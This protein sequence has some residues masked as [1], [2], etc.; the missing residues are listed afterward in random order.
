[1]E[2]LSLLPIKIL[3]LIK[4][5]LESK[6][7]KYFIL[8]IFLGI[9]GSND[10]VY[11]SD[12]NNKWSDLV[13]MYINT[14]CNESNKN[15]KGYKEIADQYSHPELA[16]HSAIDMWKSKE[17]ESLELIWWHQDHRAVRTTILALFYTQSKMTTSNAPTFNSYM[18]KFSEKEKKQREEELKFVIDNKE[19]LKKLLNTALRCKKD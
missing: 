18:R 12:Q 14:R 15:F 16:I 13:V 5:N 1:M 4:L 3:L 10:I 8:I 6:T 19:Y 17:K 7:I 2:F 9:L 11:G